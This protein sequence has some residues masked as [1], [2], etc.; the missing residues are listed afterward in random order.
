MARSAST[1]AAVEYDELSDEAMLC[2][3]K[4]RRFV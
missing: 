3:K 4:G 2:T 1:K